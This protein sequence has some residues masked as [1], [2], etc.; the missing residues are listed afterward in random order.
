V[1]LNGGFELGSQGWTGHGVAIGDDSPAAPAHTGANNAWFPG[2]LSAD[3]VLQQTVTIPANAPS[4][5]LTFWLQIYTLETASLPL[6]QFQLKARGAD[7]TLAILATYSNLD[8]GLGYQEFAVNLGA[9]LGQ[10]VQLSFVASDFS[11]GRTT[12]FALDDISLI[13]NPY[14][15]S[16]R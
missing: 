4:A 2:S 8:A 3:A 13:A 16:L 1:I 7:G 10:K 14:R 15:V 11:R 6:D 12:S 9:Y 5:L